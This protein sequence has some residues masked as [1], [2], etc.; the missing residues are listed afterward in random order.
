V[1]VSTDA[2]FSVSEYDADDVDECIMVLVVVANRSSL[3]LPVEISYRTV[4]ESQDD[5]GHDYIVPHSSSF[6]DVV[7][8]AHAD[9]TDDHDVRAAGGLPSLLSNYDFFV[10]VPDLKPSQAHHMTR[11]GSRNQHSGYDDASL[12]QT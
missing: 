3:R 12:G 11:D 8:N 9:D 5:G 7:I 10:G 4:D 2:C 6:Y 1:P